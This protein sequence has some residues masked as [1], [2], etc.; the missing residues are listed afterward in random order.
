MAAFC[1]VLQAAGT[2]NAHVRLA[3]QDSARLRSAMDSIPAITQDCTSRRGTP[4]RLTGLPG[5]LLS[6]LGLWSN[7]SAEMSHSTSLN[8]LA[9][10]IRGFLMLLYIIIDNR[11]MYRAM[12]SLTVSWTR[13]TY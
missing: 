7:P 9:S 10:A 6:A 12:L 13:Y 2:H 5:A 1:A 4:L 11:Y 8:S 3:M